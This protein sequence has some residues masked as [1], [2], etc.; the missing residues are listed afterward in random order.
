MSQLFGVGLNIETNRIITDFRM[1]LQ[2]KQGM[3]LR[4]LSIRMHKAD[5]QQCG[6][7]TSAQLE[8]VLGSFAIFPTKV[9]LQTL[10]KSFESEGCL[11]IESF[12]NALRLPLNER[13]QAIVDAAWS[14]IDSES[15]GCVSLERLCEC[16][17]V[18]RNA[19]FIDGTQTKEQ[20]FQSFCDGLSH[21]CK[22]VSQ[23][24]RSVEWLYYQLDLSLSIVDDNYFVGM[25]Q[26][27]WGCAE[28]NTQCVKKTEL[29]H[30]TKTIRHRLL[31][32]STPLISAEHV[33]RNVFR[34]FD[35]NR[36][37][38][39]DSAELQQMLIKLQVVVDQRYLDALLKRFDRNGNGVIEFEE[40]IG[41][42]MENPYK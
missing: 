11:C 25:T 6:H 2:K 33:M 22:S 23:V 28:S 35:R 21:D 34:E 24:R 20:I 8:K 41:Y 31:D 29:E 19:D 14:T 17:D 26:A 18:S 15:A 10:I 4:S 3:A 42:V 37:G 13:R 7:L 5:A 16:Y 32:L 27:V 36:S 40:F 38:S 39:L 12:M 30:I 1:H 9:Q